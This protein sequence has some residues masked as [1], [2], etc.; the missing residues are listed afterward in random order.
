MNNSS[1][2]VSGSPFRHIQ[3][4]VAKSM[5]VVAAL[6][7]LGVNQFHFAY[8][9]VLAHP[10]LNILIILVFIF[11]ALVA[12]QATIGLFNDVNALEG[13]KQAHSDFDEM[14]RNGDLV[15]AARLER[16]SKPGKVFR[17]PRILAQV[18]EMCL[19]E[20]FKTRRLTVSLAQRGSLLV[21]VQDAI[22]K[23][24][25]LLN[26]LTGLLILLGLIGTFIGLMEMVASVGQIVGG[27]AKSGSG[28]DAAI[29]GVIK[30]LEAPLTGMATGFS[31][32]LFGLLGSLLLGLLA[33]FAHNGAV[34][35]KHDF[36]H[37]L[38]GIS[39][40]E[41][42]GASAT[43]AG[44]DNGSVAA[45]AASLI[46]SFRSTQ[47]LINRSAEVMRKLA[48][49]QDK[50]TEA[51]NRVCEQIEALAYRQNKALAHLKRLDS[52]GEGVDN[53]RHD[54]ILRDKANA[55]RLAE[56]VGRIVETFQAGHAE[57]G[58]TL[59]DIGQR[60]RATERMAN[61]LEIQ[62]SRGVEEI[63][64]HLAESATRQAESER[65]ATEGQAALE[66]LVRTAAKPLD[67]RVIIDQ[68]SASVDG[69][70]AAGFGA[71][72]GAFDHA[73]EKL[74][75]SITDVGNGQREI[76]QSL[77]AINANHRENGS[78]TDFAHSVESGLS[79]GLNEIARAMDGLVKHYAT[80]VEGAATPM[81][82]P[83]AEEPPAAAPPSMPPA[84][85]D[86]VYEALT[87]R[88][89]RE[90]KTAKSRKTP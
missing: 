16:A 8:H 56:G 21:M 26:Y 11:G 50:Q 7:V 34:S 20:L 4:E 1:I 78:L 39:K 27:L 81:I 68:V 53:I 58:D 84:R 52:I 48:D 82:K 71:V 64:Q 61:G 47:G 15:G 66:K 51:L 46:G 25:S 17:M 89:Q 18:Y 36:E 24:R 31:A 41:Q 54:A 59:L 67:A 65:L 29:Q 87:A 32:S 13:L 3:M 72:A 14:D 85:M 62:I 88:L 40:M 2:P 33:R 70:L 73:L 42:P 86:A 83:V 9:A 28:S 77:A 22:G 23:E 12:I 49:R 43:S 45:L 10:A 75:S 57:I 55:N 80:M 60:Q 63:T 6:V 79:T 44:G 30:D 38:A 74:A 76:A 5:L 37:W 19:D 35:I 90:S 69:R